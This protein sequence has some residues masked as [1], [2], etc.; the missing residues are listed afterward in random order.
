MKTV[1]HPR[2]VETAVTTPR[3][4][5]LAPPYPPE[6]QALFDMVMP[7]GMEP[8]LLFRTLASC[9][10]I[11]PRFMRAG[12]LDKGPV[13]IRDRELVIHRTTARCGAVYEWGVHA[14]AFA[15]P[16][17][18]GAAWIRATV[19]ASAEDPIWEPHQAAL[20]RMC[21]EL[22]DDASIS[23]ATWEDLLRH[24]DEAQILELIYTAGLYHAV[25]FLCNGLRLPPEPFAEPWPGA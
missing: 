10:R 3:I 8:L 25:S 18:L 6:T 20:V 23:D 22:H 17:E 1:A 24:F 14:A 21:D 16:L 9:P 4:E 11:F 7:E 12:V 5:P 19:T 13:A 2:A 15:R